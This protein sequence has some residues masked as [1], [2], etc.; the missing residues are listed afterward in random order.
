MLKLA[1]LALAAMSTAAIAQQP[2]TVADFLARTNALRAKGA[3]AATSPD[4]QSLKNEMASVIAGYRADLA[5]QR[6]AGEPP[7]SCPP[8][9]GQTGLTST[10]LIREFNAI[11]P[12]DRGVSVKDAFYAIMKTRYPCKSAATADP[13]RSGR[14]A[15]AGSGRP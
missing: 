4:M 5:A 14:A 13:I 10:D 11:P 6:Q 12:G 15:A 1:A 7:H 8:P 2:T 9:R 3:E